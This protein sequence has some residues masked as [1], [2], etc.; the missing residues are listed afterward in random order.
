MVREY[1][2]I[3]RERWFKTSMQL[4]VGPVRLVIVKLARKA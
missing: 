3:F 1:V 4:F 2:R